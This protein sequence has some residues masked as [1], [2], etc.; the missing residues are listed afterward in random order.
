VNAWT[1]G[2][3][4]TTRAEALA[5]ALRGAW[6]PAP[7]P[8]SPGAAE[9]A[10]I[11]PLILAGGVG[12]LVWRRIRGTELEASSAARALKQAY[13]L[14][15]LE[16]ALHELQ[17]R[18]VLPVM[19][20]A[21]VEPVLAKGWAA[22]RLYP[23]PGL[24]PYGDL[25]L[26]VPPERHAAA[27][28]ALM[29]SGVPPAPVDLH[30]GFPDIDDRDA[31][32]RLDRSRL[33]DLD[34]VPV[35]VLAAEDHL[36]LLCLHLLRHGATRPLWLCDVAAGLESGPEGLDWDYFLAGCRRRTDAA[37]CALGLAHRLLGARLDGCPVAARAEALPR[38]L[39]PA[40]LRQWESGSGWRDPLAAS[41]RRRAG[42][43]GELA[44]HWPNPVE[45]TL[46]VGGPFNELPRLPFQV[47]HAAVRTARFV[48]RRH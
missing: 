4:G 36:R 20:A 33:A 44:R 16:A 14:H 35:R 26:Y 21:G 10:G 6:L 7:P 22:A 9:L 42:F 15:V 27:L 17:I 47:A 40:V 13:R 30:H 37:V 46:G 23:E 18:T 28:A 19:R 32:E 25:D 43:L 34:G 31:D 11:T 5:G 29:S 24:R 38:W 2:R 45:G 12:A 41:L 39:V 48:L 8:W 3:G 1:T